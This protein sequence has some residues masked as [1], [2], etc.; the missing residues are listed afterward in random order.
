MPKTYSKSF[1]KAAVR[2]VIKQYSCHSSL[3]ATITYVAAKEG[4]SPE[5]LRRWV[6]KHGYVGR[7]VEQLKTEIIRLREENDWLRTQVPNFSDEQFRPL[8]PISTLDF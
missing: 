4:C 1:R 6:K 3:W 8:E 5:I 7:T 2:Q